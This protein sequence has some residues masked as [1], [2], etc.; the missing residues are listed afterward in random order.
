MN[1]RAVIFILATVIL[2]DVL[3]SI[4]FCL[5]YPVW[6]WSLFI[7]TPALLIFLYYSFLLKDDYY[8]R[9]L[10]I[11]LLL[12]WSI[13]IL[14]TLNKGIGLQTHS[15]ANFIVK[16]SGNIFIQS[17][18]VFCR[19]LYFFALI[20]LVA[21]YKDDENF[22]NKCKFIF[23]SFLVINSICIII[24]FIFH[25]QY[26]SSY[27][28]QSEIL[29]YEERFGYKGLIFGVNELSGV[30][31]L[32][33]SYYFRQIIFHNRSKYLTL[34]L[35]IAAALLTGSKGT[36]I[37]TLVCTC[38]YLLKIKKTF[39]YFLLC[40]I[41]FVA[42]KYSLDLYNWFSDNSNIVLENSDGS[43]I[44]FLSTGRNLFLGANFKYI[45]ENWSI[46]NFIFGDGVLYSE[47]DLFDLYYFFGFASILYLYYYRRI[48]K[49]VD[50]SPDIKFIMLIIL[51]IAF[52][53]GHIIQS[54][55]FPTF[56][57]LFLLSSSFKQSFTTHKHEYCFRFKYL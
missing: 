39:F 57:V 16:G 54:A 30:Y 52:T 20:P 33:V 21:K 45:K 48:I 4:A 7:K 35:V 32:G 40:L 24:G 50:Q 56:L 47:T 10:L 55:V 27:N 8:P 18:T 5:N 2:S 17:F 25:I 38:Y 29:P 36:I 14:V 44:T 31:I 6:N 23:E 26:F 12:F 1:S 42:V 9:V 37:S 15:Y 34:I 51:V 19:Y 13:G 49:I 3:T 28:P 53:A 41:I 22:I 11:V 43:I 46:L